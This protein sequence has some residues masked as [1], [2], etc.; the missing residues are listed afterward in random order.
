[1]AVA[2]VKKRTRTR[3]RKTTGRRPV[4]AARPLRVKKTMRRYKTRSVRGLQ[5]VARR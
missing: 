3:L 4:R 1:M 2:L 5:R